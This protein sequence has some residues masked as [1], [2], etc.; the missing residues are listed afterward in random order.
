MKIFI[1]LLLSSLMMTQ[2]NAAIK[3]EVT[4]QVHGIEAERGGNVIVMVFGEDGF[5]TAH[6]K[7][8]YTRTKNASQSIMEFTFSLDLEEVA[9]KVLHDENGDGKV[10]KNRTGI[11]PKEGLGFSNGQHISLTG[12]P[13]YKHSMLSR[14]QFKQGLNI[15]I[16]YP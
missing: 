14:D 7:A 5:P 13:K 15:S 16:A 6:N 9:V 2:V 1:I 12:P 11:Y 8:L 4:I 3:H 10:T